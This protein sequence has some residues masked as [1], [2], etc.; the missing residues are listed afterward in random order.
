[1]SLPYPSFLV[2]WLAL[3]L[4]DLPTALLPARPMANDGSLAEVT[5]RAWE[6]LVELGLATGRRLA[7]E[8]EGTL[9][10][11]ATSSICF[12]AFFHEGEGDTRSALVAGSAIV[13]TVDGA[14]VTL[15]RSWSDSGAHALVDV[16]PVL[17]KGSG[18]AL[19]V[20]ADELARTSG[21]GVV[22]TARPTG[23]AAV[24]ARMR[25]LLS[26]PRTGGGQLYASRRD[27][28]GQ[29]LGCDRPLSYL[30]NAT[31]RYLAAEHNGADGTRWRTLVPAD[32][33]LLIRRVR[34]LL[35]R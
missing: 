12:Y 13:A 21:T 34:A 6:N 31:G 5:D 24:A 30:D 22:T 26:Q 10:K 15:R 16:L 20:P 7:E 28:N 35:P 29:R 8:F 19:S 17:P 25:W 3:D 33:A 2:G 14:T 27:R 32:P 4:G 23:R 9:R 18:A 11:L 1:M